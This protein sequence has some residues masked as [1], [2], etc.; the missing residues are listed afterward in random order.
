[1]PSSVQIDF[2]NVRFI[3]PPSVAFLSN[4]SHWFGNAGV[5][6]SFQGLDI[7]QQCIKYLDDS[8][9]FEQHLGRKL[10]PR[11]SCRPTTVPVRKIAKTDSYAWLEYDFLPWLIEKSGLSKASLAEVK[12]CLQE[13]FN[14]I[15][16]H[17]IHDE[18]CVFGQWYPNINEII[19]SI[20]DFGIG[21]PENVR[22]VVEGVSDNECILKAAEDGF[23][24]KSLP[25]NRGAGLYLLLLNVVQR[26]HGKVS[27]RS[28]AGYVEFVNEDGNIYSR[29]HTQCGFCVG[30][31][32]D[33][34][35]DTSR[36]PCADEEEDFEWF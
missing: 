19:V 13:L 36:I 15:S 18:G 27:I 26:F 29:A 28:G 25:T 16:D 7:G 14:N 2:S 6:V 21:I 8:M 20:A 35:L 1:M 32:I 10:D 17:T 4:F 3:K 33:I 30:T 22:K 5:S 31:T 11:S 12:T 23:S 34:V 9:F 24:T